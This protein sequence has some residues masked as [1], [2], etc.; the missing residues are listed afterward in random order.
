MLFTVLLGLSLAHI[1][2]CSIYMLSI[3]SLGLPLA[4]IELGIIYM[5]F[6]DSIGSVFSTYRVILYQYVYF[7]QPLLSLP[8]AHIEFILYYYVY[9]LQP[10]LGLPL[11]HIELIIH[12]YGYMLFTVYK[13]VSSTYILDFYSM[14]PL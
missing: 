5:P 8:V 14:P 1:E 10:L 7:P 3:A 6:T 12:V 11:A 2:V 13:S 4:H 9:F